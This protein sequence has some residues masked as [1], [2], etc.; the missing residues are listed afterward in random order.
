MEILKTL[1]EILKYTLTKQWLHF[2]I[3]EP[4]FQLGGI[5]G[6]V[7]EIKRCGLSA[8]WVEATE[9]RMESDFFYRCVN[10]LATDSSQ[11]PVTV[12][13]K[14]GFGIDLN[15]ERLACEAERFAEI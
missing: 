8:R 9:K 1:V 2:P 10:S 7:P 11:N 4:A 6:C 13:L 12:T 15:E 3:R 14:D 5:S